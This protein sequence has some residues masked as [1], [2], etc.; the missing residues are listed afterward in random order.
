M[1]KTRVYTGINTMLHY[2]LVVLHFMRVVCSDL[3][4]ISILQFEK[5]A[6]KKLLLLQKTSKLR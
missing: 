5:K 4:L 1:S 2:M 3:K 6:F